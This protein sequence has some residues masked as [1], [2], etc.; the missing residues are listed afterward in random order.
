MIFAFVGY[1]RP[2][3]RQAAQPLSTAMRVKT[4]KKTEVKA[5]VEPEIKT[6]ESVL[7]RQ[8]KANVQKLAQL[9]RAIEIK[10][11][12]LHV[13]NG[14]SYLKDL[15]NLVQSYRAKFPECKQW[16]YDISE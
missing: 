4:E 9:D 2:K 5:E 14:V 6:E 1:L 13:A 16:H 12:E 3:L 7:D 11:K 8:V 10:I 15:K